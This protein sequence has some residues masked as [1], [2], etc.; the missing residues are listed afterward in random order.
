MNGIEAKCSHGKKDGEM[1]RGRE[2]DLSCSP[3][4]EEIPEKHPSTLIRAGGGPPPPKREE[5]EKRSIFG[6]IMPFSVICYA[7]ENPGFHAHGG[8]QKT[9]CCTY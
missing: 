4:D 8:G 7:G 3:C 2:R 5:K 6:T 1:G 9:E